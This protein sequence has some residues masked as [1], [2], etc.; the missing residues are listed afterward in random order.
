[1]AK[2]MNNKS[3]LVVLSV[4][5]LCFF[6]LPMSPGAASEQNVSVEEKAEGF[7]PLFNGK[8]LTGWVGNT[9]GYA[10]RDGNIVVLPNVGG[11]NLYIEKEYS[12]FVFRFEFKLTDGANN[13]VGIRTPL[14]GDA[15]YVGMEIQILDDTSAKYNDPNRKDYYKL[16]PYQYHGSIYGVV[17]AMTGCLK[18][19][20]QWN[21]EEIVADGP[22]I[23]VNLNGTTIVDA[24]LDKITF[25]T[26]DG[27]KHPGLKNKKGHIGFLGHDDAL[28][29]RNIRIK[30]LEKKGSEAFFQGDS[31]IKP[32]S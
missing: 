18:P 30:E 15:A 14:E 31:K 8:D 7:V 5:T 1:M 3:W 21:Y 13:G 16:K 28:E 20:G 4:L 11:G 6:C 22:H 29:F 32:A 23:I 24:N 26:I 9:A 25:P 2:K 27:R 12:D 17:P 10:A 19:L